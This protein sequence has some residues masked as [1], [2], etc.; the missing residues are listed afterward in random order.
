MNKLVTY[1]SSTGFTKQY[2]NWI[3]K[4]LKAEV[5]ELKKVKASE[6]EQYECIIYGG[7]IM[8]NMIMG[9]DKIKKMNPKNLVVF[10]VGATPDSHTIREGIKT[11]NHLEDIPFYYF[12]GGFRFE[13]LNFM[14][15]MMLKTLKK[16]TAKKEN[17]T[18]Q[19]LYMEKVLG[20][21]FDHA[22]KKY[23]VP[24]ITDVKAI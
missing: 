16:S 9:L 3:A 12:E 21:S 7:W 6:I 23:I 18:E 8:G 17:K 20:T 14:V 2:A 10:A 13:Q 22:D 5:K 11:Q 19:E 1:T 24:L 15:R 4:E